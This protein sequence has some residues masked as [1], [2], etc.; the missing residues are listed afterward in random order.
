[1]TESIN[2]IVLTSIDEYRNVVRRWS[3]S[4]DSDWVGA[5]EEGLAEPFVFLMVAL[6][7]SQAF[8]LLRNALAKSMAVRDIRLNNVG[9]N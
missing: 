5:G 3:S 1:M 7:L 9:M 6:L 4:F 8:F 2:Q